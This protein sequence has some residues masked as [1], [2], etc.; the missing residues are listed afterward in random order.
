MVHTIHALMPPGRIR[1]LQQLL[2]HP[3]RELYL[4]ELAARADVSLSSAQRELARLTA[5]GLLRRTKRG[6]QT[7]YRAET[8]SPIYPELRSLLMKTVGLGEALRDGLGRAGDVRLAFIYGSVAA[9]EERP[10]SDVDI[11]VV[12]GARPRAISDLLS[13]AER[14]IGRAVNSVVLTPDEF[15]ARLRSRDRFLSAILKGPK[16]FVIGDEDEARRLGG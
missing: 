16:V 9:G 3:E 6:H 12:G 8:S 1:V 5:A 4:R 7:F 10:G 11:V 2:L 13:D 14:L 15:S